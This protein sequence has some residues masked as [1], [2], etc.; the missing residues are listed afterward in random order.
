M[1]FLAISV[2][3]LPRPLFFL[4]SILCV[5]EGVCV[6]VSNTNAEEKRVL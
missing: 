5:C 4:D 6:R 1:I 2:S 3:P